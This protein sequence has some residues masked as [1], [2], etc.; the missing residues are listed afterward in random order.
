MMIF[1]RCQKTYPNPIHDTIPVLSIGTT[2]PNTKL[3]P[4]RSSV[5]SRKDFVLR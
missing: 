2:D 1:S 5:D 3:F 4:V